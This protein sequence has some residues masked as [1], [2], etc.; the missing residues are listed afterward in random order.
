MLAIEVQF[1]NTASPMS[2]TDSGIVTDSS[3]EHPAKARSPR[4]CMVSVSSMDDKELQYAKA[5]LPTL[6]RS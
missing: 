6:L 4:C 3:D 1:S 5:R 2:V